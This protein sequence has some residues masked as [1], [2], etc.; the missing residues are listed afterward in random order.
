MLDRREAVYRRSLADGLESAVVDGALEPFAVTV[1][2]TAFLHRE[3]VQHRCLRRSEVGR[4]QLHGLM[5]LYQD[6]FGQVQHLGLERPPD[7]IE[8]GPTSRIVRF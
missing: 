2:I 4:L 3:V 8:A 1:E 6:M 5:L 7:L